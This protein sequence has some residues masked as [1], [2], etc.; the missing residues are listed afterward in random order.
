[1][2]DKIGA[3]SLANSFKILGGIPS[4]PVALFGLRFC[5][6]FSIHA[7]PLVETV[8]LGIGGNLLGWGSGIESMSSVVN[9]DLNCLFRISAFLIF[10][11]INTPWSF[12]AGIPV[13]SFF[14]F[15]TKDQ[16]FLLDSAQNF[17][18]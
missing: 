10:S 11:D 9:T 12:K 16:K 6:S 13:E 3:I 1:M 5:K 7:I 2:I 17:L 8:I 18:I 14:N 4:G 15:F